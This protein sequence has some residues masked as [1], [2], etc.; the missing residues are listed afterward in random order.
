MP[1]FDKDDFG[2]ELQFCSRCGN[3]ADKRILTKEPLCR[4]CALEIAAE[5]QAQKAEARQAP[6][7]ITPGPKEWKVIL[8]DGTAAG[9]YDLSTL[10]NLVQQKRITG[11]AKV[12]QAGGLWQKAYTVPQLA[13]LFRAIPTK[14]VE[15]PEAPEQK[16]RRPVRIPEEDGLE[17]LGLKVGP[18]EEK[19]EEMI[20]LLEDEALP[21]LDLETKAPR[22]PERREPIRPPERREPSR[23]PE[24]KVVRPTGLPKGVTAKKA[25]FGIGRLVRYT[26]LILIFAGI[27]ISI[28]LGKD[29]IK[30]LIP[31]KKEEVVAPTPELKGTIEEFY[32]RGIEYLSQYDLEGYQKAEEEFKQALEIDPEFAPVLAALAENYLRWGRA[33]G[34]QDKLAEALKLAEKSIQLDPNLA[35]GYRVIASIMYYDQKKVEEAEKSALRAVEL[36]KEDWES[37]YILGSIYSQAEDKAELAVKYLKDTV[38]YYPELLQAHVYLASLYEKLGDHKSALGHR[39]KMVE[40]KPDNSEWY[41]ALGLCYWGN[42]LLDKAISSYKKSLELEPERVPARIELVKLL[43]EFKKSYQEAQENIEILLRDY[44][45]SLSQDELKDFYFISGRIY[46]LSGSLEQAL[47]KYQEVLKLDPRHEDTYYWLGDVYYQQEQFYESE[48]QYRIILTLNPSSAR[49]YLGWGKVLYRLERTD[50]AITQYQK[51]IGLDPTYAEPHYVIGNLYQKREQVFKAIDSYRNA[52][53]LDPGHVDA[54]YQLAKLSDGVGE[55]GTAIK[56]YNLVK[57]ADPKY[58]DVTY[59][60]GELYLREGSIKKA[61]AEFRRYLKLSPKG[62]YAAQAKKA[63]ELYK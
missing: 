50:L 16:V 42:E 61:R 44:A 12:S 52:V 31:E 41:Y 27:G 24:R 49:A 38:K 59:F 20:D 21:E 55:A 29:Y 54:H 10:K 62:T 18:P 7:V 4:K 17:E 11:F 46:H 60:L 6:K 47:V 39:E 15:P 63:L 34:D 8:E 40:L 30:R 14:E 25:G 9:P 36:D 3:K 37:L 43:F 19:E 51:A 32:Q 53:K 26:A 1:P 45:Q 5:R 13:E 2:E 28:Y 58:G 22:P 23:P 33:I 57:K 35:R 56:H 48:K